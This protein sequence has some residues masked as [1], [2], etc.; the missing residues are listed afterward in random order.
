MQEKRKVSKP[1][2]SKGGKKRLICDLHIHS[3]YSRATSGECL[4]EYLDLWARRKGI[5]LVGTG[6]FTHPAWRA[7]LAETME[8][9]EEG[10][11]RL[12]ADRRLPDITAGGQPAPR[13][14]ITGE[15]SSIYKKNGRTR[16]VHNVILLPS[17]E[18][19][20][21][22]ALRLEAIGNLHSDGR[23]IL[24][25]DSRD[26]MEIT[27]EACPEAMLIPAHIWTPHFSLF[28]AFSGFDTIEECFGDMTP[29]I[30]ALETGLSSDPPMNWRLSALDGYRL[31][32][33]SDAH[34]PSKLGREA[35]I[36]EMECS[37]PALVRALSDPGDRAFRG[38]LEF[39]PEEGKYHLDGHRACGQRLTPE[40][41]E[42]AQGRCPA[43]GRK[44]TIGVLHRVEQLADRPEGYVPDHAPAFERLVPLP[45]VIA[46]STGFTVASARVARQYEAMLQ[47]LGPEFSILRELPLE[48]IE[49]AAGPCVAEGIR[50]VR[51]GRLTLLAGYDGEYGKIE[52]LNP[53]E[54]KQLS[55][56]MSFLGAAV[57]AR[58]A[59]KAASARR[60]PAGQPP[61]PTGPDRR[62]GADGAL[63]GLN[64]EQRAA[65][66]ARE[67]AVAVVAGPGTGKT[68]TL[69]A[70]IQYLVEQGVDPAGI[71]AV[72]FTNQA[73]GEMRQRLEAA[74]GT[75]PVQAMTIGTFHA[76]CLR[77]LTA[78][79][80]RVLIVD[81]GE[82]LLMAEET[83]QALNE[84]LS[85]RAL[86]QGVSRLKNGMEPGIP[87]E[88]AEAYQRR[89]EAYGVLDFDDLLLEALAL[90]E[91]A[92]GVTHLLVDEFQD[93]NRMQYRLMRAWSAAA[94]SVFVI[95]DP[96][97][98]IY[99]FRGADPQC[100]EHFFADFP[101]AQ[102]IRL[103]RNYR[104]T[105][106]VLGCAL[107][108]IAQSG[109]EQDKR[110]LTPNQGDGAR[111]RW[112][113]AG[114]EFGQ[115]LFVTKE[116]N[117]M[118]GGIDMLDTHTLARDRDSD[119]VRSFSEIALL[120]RTH[121]QAELME[122]CLRQEG[123]PYT[124]AG[125]DDLLEQ[126]EARGAAAFFRSLLYPGDRAALITCLRQALGVK[127]KTAESY[128]ALAV[129]EAAPEALAL[130]PGI[131]RYHELARA[132][133]PRADRE[134]P[135]R[136]LTDWA[137][138]MALADSPAMERLIHMAVF[139]GRME[140][141]LRKLAL[142]GE[143]DLVRS[144]QAAYLSDA[145]S[146]MTLHG[147]KG[148]EYPVVFLCGANEGLIPLDTPG[149]RGDPEEEKRL[150]YVGLTRAKEE[151]IVINWSKPSPYLSRFPAALVKRG[152]AQEGPARQGRQ[153]SFL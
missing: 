145:V 116:I 36:I 55:G 33:N 79:R 9:A 12:K 126:A 10:L 142:G 41:T 63:A 34:S 52:I 23:P 81:E 104:S 98:A 5:G 50:R 47:T 128:A 101:G 26:L 48:A 29:H 147:A 24:G 99:G 70:R 54:I 105:P 14:V 149:R 21:K 56:Q 64:G 134:S 25:L 32:S 77:Q 139:D 80:G 89:L 97:Q 140:P 123:I 107:A 68:K 40:Q 30:H 122:K 121:R 124:V 86:L 53:A 133:G 153:L 84:K 146:L 45:E 15:I 108:A 120:Y 38:T 46:A 7:L 72:T 138:D 87:M 31:V 43:C 150:F 137:R 141:F 3:K 74:L 112:L 67:R 27:L 17:L 113:S 109:P 11:Y 60:A 6:D 78:Q 61:E 135:Q 114:D 2:A 58:P 28:G 143:S 65:V 85:P 75:A 103:N 125:R 35:N 151:L 118:T 16:K 102:A 83:T 88:A 39:F 130:D 144:A 129:G 131:A 106:Q 93:M 76:I 115:A 13:F 57:P 90:E 111:V 18:A 100:F 91:A 69:V 20:E 44:I 148:L 4:P 95:G 8:P 22:L 96:D 82:A 1:A 127:K 136:L 117:R 71:M 49:R 119:K 42:Q 152:R 62:Q 110:R 132:Y 94:Q 92:R 73:A 51:A 19:A 66:M 37:Y 59:R